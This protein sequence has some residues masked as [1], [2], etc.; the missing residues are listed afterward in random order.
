[1]LE[2]TFANAPRLGG[3]RLQGINSQSAATV[4]TPATILGSNLIAWFRADLGLW[5]DS[6]LTTQAVNDGDPVGG[7]VDQSGNGNNVLQS[8][9][10]D[11]ATLKLSILNGHPVVRFNGSSD[12][13]FS[14]AFSALS[15][16][17]VLIV[18]RPVAVS[19]NYQFFDGIASSNRNCVFAD[20]SHY[21]WYAGTAITGP[22][23]TANSWAIL[24]AVFNNSGSLLHLNGGS[25]SSG[26]T[27][28]ETLTGI[29]LGANYTPALYTSCDIAEV[30]VASGAQSNTVR[31]QLD[32]YCDARYAVY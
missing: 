32:S 8:T 30:I 31:A 28:T 14:S 16:T 20:A 3:S 24:N 25:D 11:R 22:T 6:G 12:Y 4:I 7:W 15:A 27:G 9:S 5:Q 23:A 19:G 2:F 17:T 29:T 18:I 26:V 21:A 1:M 13:L 10:A